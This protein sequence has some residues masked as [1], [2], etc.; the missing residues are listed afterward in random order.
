M[1][2]AIAAL[3]SL[4][5]GVALVTKQGLAWFTLTGVL[6][7]GFV[8]LM[9]AALKE[10][11]V[12]MVAPVVATYPLITAL[13]SAVV[14]KVSALTGR[15]VAGAIVTVAGVVYLVATGTGG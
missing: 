4:C 10:A 8:L 14:L 3:S 12:S 13:V 5:F 6:N 1:P 2:F 11:P 9:Y 7:G 15:V